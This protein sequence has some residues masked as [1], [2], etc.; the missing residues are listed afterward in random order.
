MQLGIVP[1][2]NQIDNW[3]VDY[4]GAQIPIGATGVWKAFGDKPM[5]YVTFGLH[6]CTAAVVTGPGGLWLGHWWET[7]EQENGPSSHLKKYVR[8]TT[9]KLIQGKRGKKE[10]TAVAVDILDQL[11]PKAEEKNRDTWLSMKD[12]AEKKD[13][14]FADPKSVSVWYMTLAKNLQDD[15]RQ[16]GDHI[17][18]FKTKFGSIFPGSAYSENTY[19]G[20]SKE[21][22]EKGEAA[23]AATYARDSP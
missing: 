20:Y 7:A 8:Q 17:D 21:D 1:S 23:Y 9:G 13:N 6:G 4:N 5:D 19:K 12:L 3:H 22:Y 15:S 16:Y 11:T 2:D 18:L 10:F 14:P